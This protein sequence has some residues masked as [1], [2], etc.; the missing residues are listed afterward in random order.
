MIN[1]NQRQNDISLLHPSYNEIPYSDPALDSIV[2][3][4]Y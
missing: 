4:L 3:K 2:Y 1:K